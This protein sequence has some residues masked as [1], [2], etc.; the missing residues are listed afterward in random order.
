[1]EMMAIARGLLRGLLIL[2]VS[3]VLLGII[4]GV[5]TLLQPQTYQW[6]LL[7]I[8]V[9]AVFASGLV[10][11]KLAQNRGWLH[12]GVSG[13]GLLLIT[14]LMGILVFHVSP[15]LPLLLYGLFFFIIGGVAGGIGV[16]L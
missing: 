2:V 4:L 3:S 7:G 6:I 13:V 12:G 11:G 8:L 15:G 1:M 10:S 5:S 14:V 9:L 16:N